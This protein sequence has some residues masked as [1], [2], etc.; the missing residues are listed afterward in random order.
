MARC[1]DGDNPVDDDDEYSG[2]L[3]EACLDRVVDPIIIKDVDHILIDIQD[4]S[5]HFPK[6][7]KCSFKPQAL[8][9]SPFGNV[10]DLQLKKHSSVFPEEKYF[11]LCIIYIRQYKALSTDAVVPHS[12]GP[13]AQLVPPFNYDKYRIRTVYMV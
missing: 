4:P 8:Q 13:L 9:R 3:K 6:V 1:D 10:P 5:Y 2:K 11:L 7:K 12:P